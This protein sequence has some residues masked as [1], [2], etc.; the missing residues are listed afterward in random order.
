MHRCTQGSQ[1]PSQ[2]SAVDVVVV[3]VV[4]VEDVDEDAVDVVV[5]FDGATQTTL[6][7][8]SGSAKW[9]YG[10]RIERDQWEPGAL[11]VTL[12]PDDALNECYRGD[13]TLDLGPW[14]CD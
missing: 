10:V 12:D 7:L 1:S 13:N 6:D 8:P 9:V 4:V 3:L 11:R 5:D 14:P 2:R